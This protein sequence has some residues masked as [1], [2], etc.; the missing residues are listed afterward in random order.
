MRKDNWSVG[1][2][3]IA[4]R[5]RL[6]ENSIRAGINV[7]PLPGGRLALRAGYEVRY[8]GTAVRAMLALGDKL[9]I[10]DGTDLVEFNTATNSSR[11]L[12]QIAGAGPVVG[13][14]LNE[15][16]YFCTANEALE[17]DGS[18][19]RP[20]GVPD[21]LS[22]PA[23]SSG[24]GGTLLDGHYQVAMTFTDQWGRE[25]GTDRPVIIHAPAGGQLSVTVPALPVGCTA[26]LYVSAVGGSTL[27]RQRSVQVAGVVQIGSVNDDTARCETVLARAPQ[28]G[29]RLCIHDESVLA[30][31]IDR[32]VQLTRPLRPHLV[33][34]A[35]GFFQYPCAIGELLSAFGTLYVSA[36]KVY[37]L[38]N[39]QTPDVVQ[40]NALKHPAIPGTGV[41][42]PD[43][44]CAWMTRYGQAIAGADGVQLVNRNTFAPAASPKGIAGVL[45]HNGNQLIVSALRGQHSPNPLVAT[46]HFIGEVMNP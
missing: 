23:L 6:P 16:L 46:D 19:V 32:H 2:N 9:L 26:N 17:Y 45:E 27:Y 21:V 28:P 12:R 44:R 22:Q 41:M 14:V 20:W 40:P 33:D 5:D 30:I 24:S 35:R 10:A 7:D 37:A 15:R 1:A 11:V 43:G 13:D 31:A 8:S 4:S 18:I 25:G 39:A 38:S 3:N 42:L 36:D 34:R 29:H